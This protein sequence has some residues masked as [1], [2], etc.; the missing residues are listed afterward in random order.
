MWYESA[1][2]IP[3]A[4]G[5]VRNQSTLGGEGGKLNHSPHLLEVFF[6]HCTFYFV[7]YSIIYLLVIAIIYCL[8]H[9]RVKLDEGRNFFFCLLLCFKGQEQFWPKVSTQHTLIEWM[10]KMSMLFFKEHEVEPRVGLHDWQDLC[11][12]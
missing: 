11:G 9:T 4:I 8:S 10:N 3:W 5:W 1:V 7:I 12:T 2:I 6:L